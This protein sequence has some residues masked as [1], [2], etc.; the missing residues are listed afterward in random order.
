MK[1]LLPLAFALLAAPLGAQQPMPRQ[2]G[3]PMM[4][5]MMAP[6]MRTMAFTPE[7]LL[8]RQDSLALTP[9][10]ITRL[11]AL[12]DAA[13]SAQA[14]AQAAARTHRDALLRA[15]AAATPDT[16]A[17]R[18]HFFAAHSAMGNAHWAMLRATAQA[19]GLLT[20]AQRARVEQWADAMG[21]E[22]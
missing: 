8:A 5:E 19:K 15:M 21:H 1:S 13:K 20:D 12:R 18:E 14:A 7:H 11:T 6:M 22:P 17:V 3:Q 10:Q 2:H 4:H 9:Q 16:N